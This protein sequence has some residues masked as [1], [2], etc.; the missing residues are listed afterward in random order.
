[1]NLLPEI[2]RGKIGSAA[3]LA[4]TANRVFPAGSV[5]EPGAA[6]QRFARNKTDP[7]EETIMLSALLTAFAR[8]RSRARAIDTLN[9]LDDN[10]LRD[11]GIARD[12]IELFVAGKI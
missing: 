2:A 9:R 12:Q 7:Q 10:R 3:S 11:I 8:H 1:M 5:F 4:K 6:L